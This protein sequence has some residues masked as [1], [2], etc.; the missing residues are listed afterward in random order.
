VGLLRNLWTLLS[1]NIPT[2]MTELERRQ[3][4]HEEYVGGMLDSMRTYAARVVKRKERATRE[5]DNGAPPESNPA[6]ARLLRR[7]GGRGNYLLGGDSNG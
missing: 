2:R 4:L 3:T 7:R 6:V 5:E 1:D